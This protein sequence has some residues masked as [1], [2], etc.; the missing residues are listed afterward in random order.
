MYHWPANV[1]LVYIMRHRCL[2]II[3]EL[4][5]KMRIIRRQSAIRT[6]SNPHIVVVFPPHP[7]PIYPIVCLCT[8]FVNHKLQ[9]TKTEILLRTQPLSSNG[10]PTKPTDIVEKPHPCIQSR[11]FM[12]SRVL[13]GDENSPYNEIPARPLENRPH[14]QL[15]QKCWGRKLFLGASAKTQYARRFEALWIALPYWWDGG[16]ITD[17][18]SRLIDWA[19]PNQG[20]WEFCHCTGCSSAPVQWPMVLL[21]EVPSSQWMERVRHTR[22]IRTLG[23][24]ALISTGSASPLHRLL[25]CWHAHG[26]HDGSFVISSSAR[27]SLLIPSKNQRLVRV[28]YCEH[29]RTCP[30]WFPNHPKKRFCAEPLHIF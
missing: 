12:A 26:S 6:W 10:V 29:R 1:Q 8:S 14:L 22:T 13:V 2:H 7:T 18:W 9:T 20:H 4:N 21:Y 30:K 19:L 15:F 5:R 3:L 11:N 16:G 27:R 25:L 23:V 28:V 17:K 24:P